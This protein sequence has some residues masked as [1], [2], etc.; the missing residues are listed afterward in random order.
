METMNVRATSRAFVSA[1]GLTAGTFDLPIQLTLRPRRRRPVRLYHRAAERVRNRF[2]A[3][4][5]GRPRKE[6]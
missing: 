4:N 2:G 1:E 5:R 3:S 6:R